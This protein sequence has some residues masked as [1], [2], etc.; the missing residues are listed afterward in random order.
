MVALARREDPRVPRTRCRD[1][2][3]EK[4][5]PEHGDGDGERGNFITSGAGTGGEWDGLVP[6]EEYSYQIRDQLIR[7]KLADKLVPPG[8]SERRDDA[9]SCACPA[10]P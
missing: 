4:P 6:R 10:H 1:G 5:S 7:P 3:S 2:D 9:S 8:M